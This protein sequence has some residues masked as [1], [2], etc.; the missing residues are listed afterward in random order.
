VNTHLAANETQAAAL[1]I[2]AGVDQ[3]FVDSPYYP[4]TLNPAIASGIIAQADVDRAVYNMLASKFA[5][6]LFDGAIPNPENRA[7]IYTDQSRDLARRAAAESAVLLTNKGGNTL[8]LAL[9]T[10]YKKVA[11]IGPNA[12]CSGDAGGSTMKGPPS[13]SCV[14]T[15]ATDCDGNDIDRVTGITTQEACCALCSNN[16]ACNTAVLAT[17]ANICLLKTACSPSPNPA[18][19]RC[20]PGKP[21]PPQ[22]PWT[23]KAMRAMLGGY[24]NLESNNDALAD[25]HAHVVTVLEAALAG[26]AKDGYSVSYEMGVAQQGFETTGIAA[27]VALAN[28]SDVAVLVLGDGGESVGY[29][30]S[31]SCGEGADRPSLDLPGVQLDLLSSIIATGIPTIVVLIHGRPVTFGGDY[32]GSLTSKFGVGDGLDALAGAL[33][34]AWRPGCEGGGAIWDIITGV[35]SPSG[36]LAQSWPLSVGSV[37]TG[38]I[39]P[40][41]IKFTDQG[42]SGY[43]LGAPFR[44]AYPLGHGLDFLSVSYGASSAT[45]D[46][47]AQCV[48]VDVTVNNAA[49]REG[50]YVVQVYFTQALSKFSRYQRILGGFEKVWLPANGSLNVTVDVT[51]EAMA[52]YDP[53][54]KGMVLEASDYT[55]FI[56][57]NIATCSTDGLKFTISSTIT[58]L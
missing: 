35:T 19:I 17:D 45:L 24:S 54:S 51:F 33:V 40:A 4:G 18:R 5:A 31:V 41:Y 57:S 1:A 21:P 58:N 23:C 53:I 22:I 37:R 14:F 3:A 15:P 38:G 32:S 36:R 34:A 12:G 27:A 6:G 26:G 8:P 7:K 9:G 30:S 39:S 28:S 20:D 29:D 48:H 50:A 47:A 25:N 43:T 46:T 13:S 44:P 55:L 10:K 16:S 2:S 56:C 52:Y 42:G 49:P 11:L